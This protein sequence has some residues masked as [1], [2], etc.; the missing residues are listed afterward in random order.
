MANCHLEK[1]I[2][3]RVAGKLI[4]TALTPKAGWYRTYSWYVPVQV[5]YLSTRYVRML[6][7]RSK[8]QRFSTTG[9]S[10]VTAKYMYH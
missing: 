4:G 8:S 1:R 9:S 5:R 2:L 10:F 6:V 3:V 7:M